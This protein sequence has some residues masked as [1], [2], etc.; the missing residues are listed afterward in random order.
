M[1]EFGKNVFK[2]ESDKKPKLLN[3]KKVFEYLR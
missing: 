3:E 2:P 1:I